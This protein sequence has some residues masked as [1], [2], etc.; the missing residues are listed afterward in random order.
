[1]HDF[2]LLYF[3]DDIR[4]GA[5][6]EKPPQA[7]QNMTVSGEILLYSQQDQLSWTASTLVG[8]Y[9]LFNHFL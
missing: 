1:V 4:T 3:L 5:G 7:Q 8:D 6:V 2:M 9:S